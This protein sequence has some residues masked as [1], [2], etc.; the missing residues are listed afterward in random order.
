MI[1]KTIEKKP[2]R[3]KGKSKYTK[4]ELTQIITKMMIKEKKTQ[5]DIFNWLQNDLGYKDK[6][7]Y[8]LVSQ[9]KKKMS[10]IY[11]EET[12]DLLEI[13]IYELE[14]QRKIA[15]ENNDRRL[16]LDISKEINKIKGLYTEKVEHKGEIKMTFDFDLGVDINPEEE[17]N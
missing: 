3:R 14:E 1:K 2:M 7:C 5:V 16:V 11:K 13:A 15:F 9:A 10:E 12:K 8:S 4:D 6:W 17:E